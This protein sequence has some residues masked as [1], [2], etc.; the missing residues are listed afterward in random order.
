MSYALKLAGVG[1]LFV[2]VGVI[3]IALFGAIWARI[4]IG[5]AVVIVIGGLLFFAWRQDQKAR[6][7]RAGLERI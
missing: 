4:G 1:L 6:E 7:S 2:I 3:G 5:A